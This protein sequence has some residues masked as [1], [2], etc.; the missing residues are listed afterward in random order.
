MFGMA[1]AARLAAKGLTFLG[2][3]L[4]A[5]D[6]GPLGSVDHLVTCDLQ[7]PAVDR[8]GDGLGLH[9]AVDESR[10]RDRRGARP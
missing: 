10:A 8:V 1:I 3:G 2:V 4:F 5:R 6:A 9:G 7:Q